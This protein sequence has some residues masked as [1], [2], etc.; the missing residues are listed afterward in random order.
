[1]VHRRARY[2]VGVVRMDRPDQRDRPRNRI[3]E[4]ERP[5]QT[6]L[7]LVGEH[8]TDAELSVCLDH[9]AEGRRRCSDGR[10]SPVGGGQS[11]ATA[12]IM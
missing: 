11:P 9:E 8:L 12:R 10:S 5:T 3:K 1:M 6:Q 7:G 4:D 2:G